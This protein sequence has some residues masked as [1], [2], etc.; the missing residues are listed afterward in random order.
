MSRFLRLSI[1]VTG[2][3]LTMA[4]LLT[5]CGTPATPTP[6]PN[7][8]IIAKVVSLTVQ[9][10]PTTYSTVGQTITYTYTVSNAG[11]SPLQGPVTIADD[12]MVVVSCPNLNTVGNKN[13][14]LDSGES[15][16]CTGGYPISQADISNGSMTNTATASVGGQASNPVPTTIQAQLNKVLTLAVSANPT[17]YTGANQNITYTYVITNTGPTTLG[18]AQF[19]VKDDRIPNL[20]NCGQNTTTLATNQTVTCTAVY[21]T[22]AND[23]LVSQL[24]NNASATGAG[25]GT[26]Q[27]A[28]A[29]VTYTGYSGG[30]T[31]IT[32]SNYTR[33]STIQH[34]VVDGEWLL[35][36]ARCYGADFTAVRNANPQVIDPDLIYPARVVTVPNIGSNGAIYGPPCVV[37]Y[38]VVS[39]DTW[40][41]IANK[42]NADVEI[43]MA[44]NKDKSVTPG[45]TLKIPNN[46]KQSGLPYPTVIPAT[47]IPPTVIPTTAVPTVRQP[48][49]ITF[50]PGNPTSVTQTGTIGTPDTIRYVFNASV[51]QILTV[52]LTVPTND[53]SLGIYGPNNTPLKQPDLTNSWSGT[54]TATG[55]YAI[56]LV[57]STGTQNKTYTLVVT[58]TNPAPVSNVERVVD[59]NPGT[60][61]SNPSHLS[62]FSA[63]LYFQADGG[64]GAGAELWKYDKGLN[65]ASRVA[66]I[67]PG[68][69]GSQPAF[70]RSFKDNMLYFSANGNDG[71]GTELWRF[72]GSSTGRV[73]D[74]YSGP[75]S[76]SPSY[77][78]EFNGM[79]YF[80]ANGNDGAGVEL[81]RFDG[82]TTTRAA[83]INPGPG[84]SN[85]SYLVVY[86]NALY[87]AATT[88]N[89]GTELW[90]FDGTT[91]TL[92]ADIAPGV[93]NANP[94]F[95]AV[96][97]NILYFSANGNNGAGNELWKFDGTTA[98]MA[99]DINP[100]AADSAPTYLTGFN[101]ALFFGA[102]GNNAGF[103][104][105]R[106][107]GTTATLAA[108]INPSGSSN[109]AYLAV[110][111]NE[112]YFQANANDGAGTELW[113][114]KGP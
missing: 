48:I 52:K 35:Q 3:L 14:S 84:N 65:A 61:S 55:Q 39:G 96:F 19:V 21:T 38:K 29:T 92:A 54:L 33:G 111:S 11:T 13:N 97:N 72:N 30:G 67:Y 94:A 85:P 17:T 83:D 24:V 2:V 106:F 28:S 102:V 25:A 101:N 112:L 60:A 12:K 7:P 46:S 82:N 107:D 75:E 58:L 47:A 86:N 87:F 69:P 37:F 64:D 9:A 113:R 50:P 99:A 77:M 44:A 20:I 76:S 105:W 27:N 71:A 59:I 56:D 110:Y 45:V 4:C 32:P 6:G 22:T 78:T 74:L 31:A 62:P 81:W 103:E 43:L 36:I 41:S 68:S 51:N 66:D 109:P 8:N 10:Q 34:S 90:K 40:Q 108:D 15:I 1:L 70:L 88:T 42:F 73:N 26:I 100:G 49:P 23:L 91:A 16:T 5:E 95:L 18:P 104:L 89:G 114:Y 63:Q 93:G 79:L 98:S 80:S 57:S 53:V